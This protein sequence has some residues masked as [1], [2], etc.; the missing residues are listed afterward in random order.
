[1]L[2]FA[3]QAVASVALLAFTVVFGLDVLDPLGTHE[4]AYSGWQVTVTQWSALAVAIGAAIALAVSAHRRLR[5]LD[6]DGLLVGIPALLAGLLLSGLP[7][8][9]AGSAVAWA[10]RQTV[11][12]ADRQT[13]LQAQAA[14]ADRHPPA[15]HSRQPAASAVLAAMVPHASDLGIDWYPV[16]VP[17]V[18]YAWNQNAVD[19]AGALLTLSRRDSQGAWQPR[20][21]LVQSLY[22]YRTPALASQAAYLTAASA[23]IRT[24]TLNGCTFR[25]QLWHDGQDHLIVVLRRGADVWF[26]RESVTRARDR[27]TEADR[28]QLIRVIAARATTVRSDAQ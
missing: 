3:V 15:A 13:A 8:A 23:P 24:T 18:T 2:P 20:R 27:I 22:R 25:T 5:R 12:Y 11:S 10:G 14:A 7:V 28:L 6:G 26:D 9:G 16:Q 4:L 21:F 17:Q 19:G 1:V